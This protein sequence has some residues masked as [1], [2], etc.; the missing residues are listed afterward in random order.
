MPSK[1]ER[2][3]LQRA[4]QQA[5]PAS[6]TAGDS[7]AASEAASSQSNR[8]L[9]SQTLS[10]SFSGPLPHPSLL[11]RYN[12]VVENGAERVFAMAERNQAHR[13]RLESRV[14]DS[15][16]R[17]SYLGLGA[18]L[19]VSLAGIGA[20][21][22]AISLGRVIEGAGIIGGTLASMVGTFVYG[23]RSRRKER[24]HKAE[25]MAGITHD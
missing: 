25:L 5:P 10:A 2:R 7:A 22:Y 18:A 20:G 15:E 12:E 16:I 23:S 8:S 4:R 6:R 24:E 19:I 17:T 3:A 9:A 13:H 21:V 1:K 11:A 14:V